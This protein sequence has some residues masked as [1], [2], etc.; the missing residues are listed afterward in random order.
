MR[1]TLPTNKKRSEGFTLIEV[2]IIAPV[3]V[4]AIG[5]FVSLI[6][7]MVGDVLLTRDSNSLTFNTQRALDRIEQDIRLGT[8]FL[9]TTDSLTAPQGSNNNFTGNAPF[10]NST[11]NTFIMSS[12]TTDEIAP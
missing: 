8:Q 3:V 2:L 12:V 6:V 9:T 5:G 4:L 11:A 7:S 1:F 10:T